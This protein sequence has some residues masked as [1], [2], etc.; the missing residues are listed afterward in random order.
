MTY[1]PDV[2]VWIAMYSPGHVHHSTAVDWFD[3][4]AER[5]VAFCRVTQMGFLRLLTNSRVMG[6]NIMTSAKAWAAYD[7]LLL[8]P[9]IF[10]LKEPPGL[11]ETWRDRMRPGLGSNAWTDAYLSA[12]AIQAGVTLVTFDA[13]LANR[14][15]VHAQ[16]LTV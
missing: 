16:L 1:F 9:R 6:E 7:K 12:F 5:D 14:N 10:F 13:Q 3:A 8:V 4:S 2:N 15:G 11:E